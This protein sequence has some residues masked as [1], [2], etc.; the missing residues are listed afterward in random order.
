MHRALIAVPL[1][2]ALGAC[3]EAQKSP[4]EEWTLEGEGG[5]EFW[6]PEAGRGQTVD[7]RVSAGSSI[8]TFESTTLDLGDGVTVNSVTVLDGWTTTANLTV[9]EDAELGPRTA[10]IE[11]A[12]G[13]WAIDEA[14]TV[15]DDSFTVDPAR[16]RIGETVQVEMIGTNTEWASGS[17]WANFGDDVEVLDVQILSESYAIATVSVGG[18]AVPG[19]RDVSMS[20]LSDV[21]TLYDGFTVD[22]V[23]LSATFDPV[24]VTQ[25]ETVEFTIRGA[26]THFDDSTDIEFYKDGLENG[27]VVI[28]TITVLDAENLWGRMTVSN[29]AE[30]DWRDVMVNTGDEGVYITDAFEVIGGELDL[31]DVAIALSFY[32]YRGIDNSTGAINELVGA[33]A[34]FYIPLDP[35]CYPEE[36]SCSDGDDEDND[37]FTD[38]YDSD[39]E[40]DPACGGGPQPYDA[41]GVFQTYTTGGSTDCP[42][43]VTVSAGD[44]VWFESECNVV[45]LD[46]YV[47]SST[48]MIYY[49][50]PVTLSD[51]CFDQMYDL[52]TEGEEGF[53]GEYV[54]EEVQPTV[55]ADFELLDPAFWNDLT[56][57][58]AEDFTYQWTP[59]QTYGHDPEAFF[60]TQISGTLVATGESGYIGAIPWDDGEH[61]Y[62]AA[63]LSELEAGPV[64]FMAYSV[65]PE[66]PEFGFPFSTIQDNV[67]STYVAVSGNMVLE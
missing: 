58:R 2:V 5:L 54:L 12:T 24:Q 4:G 45:T 35:P 57:S 15:V 67:S 46:K 61:T 16:A 63:E 49:T 38:C 43:P 6:P 39:C 60:V 8:F 59:A 51:Y 41:N 1:L 14:L 26:G 23:A 10:N 36:T 29:A 9:A 32:V 22:R 13:S 64:T 52:H 66:G 48:G 21:T 65:I 17:T 50:A 19:T 62:S 37:G 11:S 28:D 44:H 18:D 47:D 33:S 25:G 27:D 55:P 31:S 20:V 56:V 30:L 53:I 3:S 40:S 42:F 7:A 34:L